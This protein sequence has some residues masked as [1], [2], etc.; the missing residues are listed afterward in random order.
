M[1]DPGKPQF[2][3]CSKKFL[4]ALLALDLKQERVEL[5]LDSLDTLLLKI[6]EDTIVS[7]GD[8]NYVDYRV[9]SDNKKDIVSILKDAEYKKIFIDS[10]QFEEV[11][12]L[13]KKIIESNYTINLTPRDISVYIELPKTY[14]EYLANLGKKKRHEL[15]RKLNKFTKEFSEYEILKGD[16]KDQFISFIELHKN[17]SKEKK[18]FITK[19]VQDFFY[20]LLNIDGWTIYLLFVKGEVVAGNFCFENKEA[21]YLYNS[22]KNQRFDPFSVGI[23]LTHHLIKE[24]IEQKKKTFDFLKGS[25]RYKFDLGGVTKQLYDIEIKKYEDTAD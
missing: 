18:E 3:F 21:L 2:P 16:N 17:S 1:L 8:R 4:K 25:E 9:T 5:Y 11:Q 22:G 15:K 20:R 12:S 10:V 6:E 7:V 13:S 24:S 23:Y 14:D 19:D